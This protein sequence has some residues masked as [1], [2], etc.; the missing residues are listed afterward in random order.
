MLITHK[1]TTTI[2]IGTLKVIR[3]TNEDGIGEI[4]ETTCNELIF[5]VLI[6]FYSCVD[7]SFSYVFPSISVLCD[8][9]SI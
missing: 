3:H 2:V 5:L 6:V 7:V 9:I 4:P 1:T 8:I